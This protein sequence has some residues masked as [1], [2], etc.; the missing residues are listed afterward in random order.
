MKFEWLRSAVVW[1]ILGKSEVMQWGGGGGGGGVIAA[2]RP[3]HL[4]V[5]FYTYCADGLACRLL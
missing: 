1:D 4:V 2:R 3:D 5:L